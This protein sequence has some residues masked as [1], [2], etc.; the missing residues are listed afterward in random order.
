MRLRIAVLVLRLPL[1]RASRWRLRSL[2]TVLRAADAGDP[3]AVRAVGDALALDSLGPERVWR[4]WTEPPVAEPTRRQWASPLVAELPADATQVPDVLVDAA[5]RDWL[6]A[7]EARL[8]SLLRRWNRAATAAEGEKVRVL[9]RLALGDEDVAVEPQLLADTATRFDHPICERARARLLAPGAPE[10]VDLYCTAALNSSEVAAFCAEHHLAPA[11]EVQRAVFFVRTGQHEQYRALDPEGALLSLGYRGAP[12]DVRSALRTAMT[13][14]GDIDVLRVLAGQRSSQG[15]FASLSKQE[16]A[17]LVR[18]L[19]DLRD[20]ERLWPLV[21]LMPLTEAVMAVRGFADWRPSG[22]DDRRVF[23]ALRA[24]DPQAVDGSMSILSGAAEPSP[25]PHTRIRLADLD[26]RLVGITELDFS[27]DGT[28]LAFVGEGPAG[29][30]LPARAGI[31]DLGSGTLSRLHCDFT[32]PL[33]R[34]AHLGSG[35]MVVAEPDPYYVDYRAEGEKYRRPKIHHVDGSG[36]RALDPGVDEI[37]GLKR[38]AG[39]RAFAVSAMVSETLFSEHPMLFIGGPHGD[40]TANGVLDGL[41]EDFEPLIAAVDPEGR[42]IAIIDVFEAAVVADLGGFVVNKLDDSSET[43]ENI[44]KPPVAL[45]PS[46]L[47]SCTDMGELKVWHE[48]LTS[49]EPSMTIPVWSPSVVLTALAWSPA[50]NRF[51]AVNFT[52]E[53]HLELLDVPPTR[54][55]PVPDELISERIAL[56]DDVSTT[57]ITRLSPGGDV[58]A[59]GSADGTIDLY[60]LT[61][62]TLRPFIARPMGLMA[63]QELAQVVELQKQPLLDDGSRTTLTLLRTC[64]EH[65]FR[66]DVGIGEAAGVTAPGDDE[67]SLGECQER[68]PAAET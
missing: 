32:D 64:L 35:T 15:D 10:A 20:W 44:P 67:I 46:T 22:E 26:E 65:R 42:L 45:S 61:T 57:L 2:V 27:P 6:D 55:A 5:W 31:V 50:L 4:T 62:L 37:M 9:S 36:V 68:K 24:A 47:V 66:H 34:V 52:H 13:G 1:G 29:E 51:V 60:V 43:L 48:P 33:N 18:Q 28:Q 53:L 21:L 16:R 12:P 11:D 19:L 56:D 17:Y 38:I 54:D 39:D 14:L 3:T 7:H 30:P 63:H 40:L 23:E 59:V 25:A 49:A 41:G 58:L 8:W